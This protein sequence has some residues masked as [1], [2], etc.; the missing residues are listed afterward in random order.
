MEVD[1]SKSDDGAKLCFDV[2]LKTKECDD[3]SHPLFDASANSLAITV[4]GLAVQLLSAAPD[5]AFAI[6]VVEELEIVTQQDLDVS[7]RALSEVN[8]FRCPRADRASVAEMR[9]LAQGKLDKFHALFATIARGLVVSAGDKA[10]VTAQLSS[11]RH[12]TKFAKSRRHRTMD[13]RAA[14]NADALLAQVLIHC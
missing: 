12:E 8:P 1:A 3:G 6:R 4:N 2:M 14:V 10:S 7:Q 5:A 13:K 11:L 9:A